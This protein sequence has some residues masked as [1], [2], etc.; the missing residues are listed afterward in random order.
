MRIKRFNVIKLPLI[1]LTM[2][3]RGGVLLHLFHFVVTL[4]LKVLYSFAFRNQSKE[5]TCR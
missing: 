3:P 1:K 5:K 2:K 4:Y